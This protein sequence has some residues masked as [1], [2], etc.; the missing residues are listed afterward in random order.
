MH[1]DPQHR[2]DII[3]LACV[4]FLASGM[5]LRPGVDVEYNLQEHAFI[6]KLLMLQQC[7][8]KIIGCVSSAWALV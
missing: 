2:T 1:I 8:L 3:H 7:A 6:N 4:S 5:L